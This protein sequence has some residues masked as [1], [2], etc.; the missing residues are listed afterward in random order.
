MKEATEKLLEKSA[1]AI[2]TARRTLAIP[3]AEAAMARAYYAM[4]YA[5]EALL[6]ERGLKFRKHAGVHAAFGEHL[7]KPGIVDAKYHHWLLHAFEK[8]IIADYEVDKTIRSEEA[9]EAI[10]R[11]SE[12]LEVARRCLEGGT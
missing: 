6:F 2:E 9:A 3:D 5:A 8:R 7:A 12:F 10:R 11:A 4:F 1:R